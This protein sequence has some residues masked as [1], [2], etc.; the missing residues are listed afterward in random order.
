[1]IDSRVGSCRPYR[2]ALLGLGAASIMS[3]NTYPVNHS[4][5]PNK[6]RVAS[7][8]DSRVGRLSGYR[9]ALPMYYRV[10]PPNIGTPQSI[11]RRGWRYAITP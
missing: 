9:V 3:H 4:A 8:S 5:R 7:L 10:A 6:Y 1:M 2:V 11:S